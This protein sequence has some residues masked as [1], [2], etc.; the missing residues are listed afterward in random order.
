MR[1]TLRTHPERLALGL[2]ALS[3]GWMLVEAAA[4][5]SFSCCTP[6]PSPAADLLA[7]IAMTVAMMVPT[8][9]ASLRDVATRSYRV[10]RVRAVLEY[11]LGYLTW[12][13]VLGVV[14]VAA[15]QLWPA[16]HD[17][18]LAAALCVGAAVW[19]LIP[20]RERW[21]QRCHR[22]IPLCP[23][24]WRADLDALRQGAVNGAP[25]VAMCWPLMV[26]CTITGHNLAMMLGG[27][28]LALLEKRMFRLERR[29]L[30]L[31]ALSLAI[32]TV[33]L[34]A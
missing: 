10:R 26:A 13:L 6:H 20:A 33:G 9:L 32:W 30:V 22:R 1:L 8:T 5:R 27:T 25:C 11:L 23:I 28:A 2:V 34:S 31:G 7:W 12:W 16:M 17:L 14:V 19:A 15:R 29:P 24:G 3:W 21:F 18:R 4:A